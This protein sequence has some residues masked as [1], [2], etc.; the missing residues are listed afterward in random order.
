MNN[1]SNTSNNTNS[2]NLQPLNTVV[3]PIIG[4]GV[5]SR[6]KLKI[7]INPGT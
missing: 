1:N 3:A 7:R 4:N 5:G 6:M 2:I